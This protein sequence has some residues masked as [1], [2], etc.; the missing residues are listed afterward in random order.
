MSAPTDTPGSG[1]PIQQFG[2]WF[3]AARKNRRI[4][5]PEAMCLSTINHR[6]FPTARMVLLKDFDRRGF[7]FFTNVHSPKARELMARPWAALT[8][9]WPPLGRQI[10]IEGTVTQLPKR[11]A[12]AYFATRPRAS[13]V[14]SW[15][16]R[17]SEPLES[18]KA[19]LDAFESLTAQFA[20]QKVPAPPHW[21]GF[22]ITPVRVEFW[23][24][25]PNR[26]HDR[27]LYEKQSSGRWNVTRLY[28]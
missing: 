1:D 3:Q 21:Q 2:R 4:A 16:S 8:F 10:R 24:E 13:Q 5:L 25:G 27:W 20:G 23:Q 12:D 6:G 11:V 7:N 14:G 22:R 26:L 9:H 19:L 15:T 18:R 17:Q 28:P